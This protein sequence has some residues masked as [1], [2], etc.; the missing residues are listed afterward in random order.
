MP[1]VDTTTDSVSQ[2][3]L[4]S[5]KGLEWE[6]VYFVD[7]EHVP[8]TE[9]GI[10]ESASA[11]R[12]AVARARHRLVA[13]AARETPVVGILRRVLSPSGPTA[14]SRPMATRADGLA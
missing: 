3:S 7:M 12:V 4:D 5:A 8:W 2:I 6:L 14:G 10:R 1:R 11:L 9:N 13:I